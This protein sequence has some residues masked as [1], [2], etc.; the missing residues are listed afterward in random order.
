MH[1]ALLGRSDDMFIIRGVNIYP[2]QVDTILSQIPGSGS[3]YQIILERKKDG[4]DYMSLRVERAQGEE[5]LKDQ[6]LKRKIETEIKK[7]I[8]VSGEVTIVDYGNLPRSE[9]KSKRVFDNRDLS[10]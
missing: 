9:R 8:L 10:K 3:E 2:G 5:P 7:Q 1:D 4:K 6:E